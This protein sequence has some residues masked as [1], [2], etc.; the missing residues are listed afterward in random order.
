MFL[1]C[2]V[3]M[4]PYFVAVQY[5]PEFLSRPLIPSP[6]FLGLILAAC[7]NLQA[8]LERGSRLS[9]RFFYGSEM[10]EYK[11]DSS[12]EEVK[13]TLAFGA[14]ETGQMSLTE[15]VESDQ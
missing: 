2:L 7:G 11:D 3:E 15:R 12:D 13:E 4:H 9:P 8:Y 14:P 6:P 5:H 10:S 1:F